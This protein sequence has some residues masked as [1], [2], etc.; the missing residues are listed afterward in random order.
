MQLLRIM[1]Q[2]YSAATALG[3][4][5]AFA[6]AVVSIFLG[7]QAWNV[8]EGR[9]ASEQHRIADLRRTVALQHMQQVR[10]HANL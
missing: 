5:L 7:M 8:C 1:S 10:A 6:C 4:F 3:A 2:Q 9:T